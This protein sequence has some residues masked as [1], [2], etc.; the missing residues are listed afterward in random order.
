MIRASEW[1][2]FLLAALLI[3]AVYYVGVKTDLQSV[4][5]LLT[6]VGNTYTGRPPGGGSFQSYPR[7]PG[8]TTA[9]A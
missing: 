2:L 8:S 6:S 9:A 3:A 4:T 5:N 1:Y 7:D